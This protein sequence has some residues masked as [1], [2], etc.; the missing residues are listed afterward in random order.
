M[1]Q[2]WGFC[3][4]YITALAVRECAVPFGLSVLQVFMD[5]ANLLHFGFLLTWFVRGLE[6]QRFEWIFSW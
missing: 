5:I 6:H 3:V 2:K 1:L 4:I